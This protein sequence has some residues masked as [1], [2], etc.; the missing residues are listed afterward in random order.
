[1]ILGCLGFLLYS[2]CL[3]LLR[4]QLFTILFIVLQLPDD[5]L[6][7]RLCPAELGHLHQGGPC[8]YGPNLPV[9]ETSA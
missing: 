5:M 3:S 1:M 6:Q 9:P 2:S 8:R 4:A 7:A